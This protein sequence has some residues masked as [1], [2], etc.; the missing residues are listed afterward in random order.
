MAEIHLESDSLRM[1]GQWT[2]MLWDRSASASAI[3][4]AGAGAVEARIGSE[5]QPDWCAGEG[6]E[7]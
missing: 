1:S 7:M 2:N 3:W 6:Q 4:S 5:A